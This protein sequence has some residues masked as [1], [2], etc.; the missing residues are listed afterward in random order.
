MKLS[1]RFDACLKIKALPSVQNPSEIESQYK[2]I[3]ETLKRSQEQWKGK[4]S[5]EEVKMWIVDLKPAL[6]K[7]GSLPLKCWY[8]QGQVQRSK[9]PQQ[10]RYD[11]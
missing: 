7:L 6:R 1:T 10:S 3:N 5:V 8:K 2:T 11:L 4:K 9:A